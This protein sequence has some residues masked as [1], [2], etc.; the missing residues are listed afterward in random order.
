VWGAKPRGQTFF[1]KKRKLFNR[2][3]PTQKNTPSSTEKSIFV[4]IAKKQRDVN[5]QFYQMND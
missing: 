1:E 2:Q 4:E 5:F 3:Y